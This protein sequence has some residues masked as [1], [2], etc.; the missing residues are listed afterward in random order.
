MV[1]TQTLFSK[2]AAPGKEQ[3]TVTFV[4]KSDQKSVDILMDGK[5]FT[6]YIRTE[7]VMK[8]VLYP[9][10]NASGSEVTRGFPIK[11]LN[12]SIP[13]G[14]SVTFRYRMVI[15]NGSDL[16]DEAINALA[17]EFAKKY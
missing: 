15:H 9:V 13:A 6:S 17:N 11:L 12:Y 8:P 4:D 3:G 5:L 2:S 16:S 7:N 14:K 10:V 1:T